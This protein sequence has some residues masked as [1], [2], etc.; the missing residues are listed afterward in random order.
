VR[1]STPD[2]PKSGVLQPHFSMDETGAFRT[3]GGRLAVS[4]EYM[5][6]EALMGPKTEEQI[7]AMSPERWARLLETDEK[8]SNF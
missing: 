6:L 8:A 3:V 2:I 5:D 7:G 4:R 1:S